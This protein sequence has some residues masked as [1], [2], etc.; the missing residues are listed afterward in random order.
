M[1]DDLCDLN[2]V[3]YNFD[4]MADKHRANMKIGH[5]NQTVSQD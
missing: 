2:N 4:A 3:W 1:E 5:I